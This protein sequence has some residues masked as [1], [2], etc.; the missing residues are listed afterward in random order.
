MVVF[1]RLTFIPRVK[2]SRAWCKGTDIPFHQI[3]HDALHRVFIIE[4]PNTGNCRAMV[5][6]GTVQKETQIYAC[7]TGANMENILSIQNI[8][9]ICSLV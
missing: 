6:K 1:L 3:V 5:E 8:S 4:D 7:C 2:E 9:K